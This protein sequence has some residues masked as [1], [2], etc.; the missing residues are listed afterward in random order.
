MGFLQPL[1][2]QIGFGSPAGAG[3]VAKAA[4]SRRVVG[5]AMT[6][7]SSYLIILA[8]WFRFPED[9]LI[10]S[11]FS[12]YSPFLLQ[13]GGEISVFPKGDFTV[14]LLSCQQA[15]VRP[16]MGSVGEVDPVSWTHKLL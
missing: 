16:S 7:H 2:I 15:W 6:S 12:I 1:Q 4:F 5:W 9:H 13:G 14:F 3:D 8:S 11:P 10:P